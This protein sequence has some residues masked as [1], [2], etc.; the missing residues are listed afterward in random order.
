MAPNSNPTELD[1]REITKTAERLVRRI[2]ERFPDSGLGRVCGAIENTCGATEA[3]ILEL[4]RPIWPL[5]AAAGALLV[6]SVGVLLYLLLGGIEWTQLGLPKNYGNFIGL[7]E[8]TLGTMVF[9][10]AYFIF[11]SS[12]E[13]RW[14]QRRVLQALNELRSF[15]HVI[16]MHQLTKDPERLLVS[17]PDTASSP[18]R[19]L[20]PFL[21]GRYLDYCSEM[22]SLLSKLAALWAQ[23]F[24]ESKLLT[25]VDEIEMLTNGLSRK[26]WQKMMILNVV[27]KHEDEQVES[28]VASKPEGGSD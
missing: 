1:G 22:L 9:L 11:I 14:K 27:V 3:H 12:L 19:N 16:D 26:I 28:V 10:T 17:G 13:S 6:A 23:A 20:S 7:L 25:A 2:D 8:P 18:E 24:P 5:R 21:I 4:M 15:A